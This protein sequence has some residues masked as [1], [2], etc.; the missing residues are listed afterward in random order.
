M[1]LR[2]IALLLSLS[3]AALSYDYADD[4]E[5]A[6]SFGGMKYL[7]QNYEICSEF[8]LIDEDAK[9]ALCG[10]YLDELSHTD[11]TG[12]MSTP[13]PQSGVVTERITEDV[14]FPTTDF[15]TTENGVTTEQ[16]N[17]AGTTDSD[18]SFSTY[19]YTTEAEVEATVDPEIVRQPPVITIPPV[20]ITVAPGGT[21]RFDCEAKAAMTPQI[22]LTRKDQLS[23]P[24][25]E[26][27]NAMSSGHVSQTTINS[28]TINNVDEPNE[29]WYTCLACN[30]HGCVE[31]DAYLTVL[32]LCKGVT[33]PGE[34]EC[35]G[36][37]ELGHGHTCECPSFCDRSEMFVSD[38]VCSN[39]CE[40]QFNECIMKEDACRN[41]K[42]GIE[43][44]NKGRCGRIE[45]PRIL[46][47]E[48]SFG[49]LEMIEGEELVL[50]C[51]AE[52][53]PEPEIIWYQDDEI[54]GYGNF[55]IKTVSTSD[56]GEYTCEAVNC[57]TTK[58]SK[59]LAAVVVDEVPAPPPVKVTTPALVQT[60]SEP[61]SF[62][63]IELDAPRAT[64]MVSFSY[65][66]QVFVISDDSTL[67]KLI[68]GEEQIEPNF[69]SN[70]YYLTGSSCLTHVK[71]TGV[72][73]PTFPYLRQ[74][75][76]HLHGKV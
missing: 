25:L 23:R 10:A 48:Y 27:F 8:G 2:V 59:R 20:N 66:H 21:G 64:C 38:W 60:T 40:E 36:N 15:Y 13:T 52:G 54:V 75:S 17:T 46:E 61:A 32:D 49:V 62:D 34:K 12:P 68:L 43:V 74:E 39:Y 56:S 71:F 50:E 3:L 37:Y 70:L 63:N 30:R 65:F 69:V 29:G 22:T 55:L 44:L 24:N 73:R 47:E 51:T 35:V 5:Q 4:Q 18:D 26:H 45:H 11:S 9:N 42:F 7:C 28:I 16:A 31:R 67:P 58:V 6:C 1:T 14:E 33:C 19:P 41:D 57:M 72:R 76:L 53:F